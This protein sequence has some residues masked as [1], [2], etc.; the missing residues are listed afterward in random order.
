MSIKITP[1]SV[2]DICDGASW[3]VSDLDELAA[4]VAMV[5]AGQ[6]DQL[7]EILKSAGVPVFEASEAARREAIRLLTVE[8]GDPYHRDGWMFQ[9]MSW[10]AAQ[11]NA[12][13]SII[14]TPHMI[15]AL[16]GFDGIQVV[17]NS[18]GVANVIL[19]EDKATGRPRET[20]K[21]DV[22]PDFLAIESGENENVLVSEVTTLLRIGGFKNASEIAKK[23]IWD[24]SR[25]FKAS[26]TVSALHST[27]EGRSRL[28]KGYE[29]QVKGERA[30]RR[31]DTFFVENLRGWM[32]DLAKRSKE[33]LQAGMT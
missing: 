23:V 9:V 14:R 10:I 20:I 25:I 12:Q 32:D 33:I 3:V 29:E 17:T 5:A 1:F 8:E 27:E 22:W 18:E 31:G 19:F 24:K 16:K 13:D 11:H 28:F 15:K 21:N 6:A 2:G 7:E 30:R 4:H 26:I